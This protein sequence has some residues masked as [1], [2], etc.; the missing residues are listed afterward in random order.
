MII[1]QCCPGTVYDAILEQCIPECQTGETYNPV[2]RECSA[3][4]CNSDEELVSVSDILPDTTLTD[5]SCNNGVL[6]G[7]VF[8]LK[9][10]TAVASCGAST[11]GDRYTFGIIDLRNAECCA[12]TPYSNNQDI[13]NWA[14]PMYHNEQSL[15]PTGSAAD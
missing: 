4:T 2:S 3:V 10:N 14:P 12:P 7:D 9:P 6:S 8:P 5:G 15:S 13:D 11:N 1:N